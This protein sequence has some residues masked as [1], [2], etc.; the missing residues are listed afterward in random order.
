MTIW[1]HL[2]ALALYA[3]AAVILAISFARDERRLPAVA[4]GIL[5]GALVVHA[6]ALVQYSFVW[7]ELPLVGLGPSL[8]SLGL[9]VGLG[10]LIASTFGHATTV[11]LVLVPLV[12]ALMGVAALVGVEPTGEAPTFR[13]GW[14]MLH[15]VFA[16]VGY[17]GLTVAFAA[18][19]MYLLQ[20]R[21]LKSKRFGAIFHF[22]P[23]LETLDRLGRRGLLIGFPFLTIALLV[24]WAWTTRFDATVAPGNPKLLW[25]ILS[26][27]VFLVALLARVGNGARSQ[28]GA[29]ASVLGFILV[30]IIYV[31]LRVQGSHGGAFL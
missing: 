2:L 17:V 14:F 29:L 30:V 3:V 1:L 18:G 25:V 23:P 10:T 26:W 28:R 7:D 20:F 6:W 12:T 27:V 13:G 5:A 15:V 24:G 8:S 9:L 22:F 31:V 4:R 11:G 16:F 19:L 21:E